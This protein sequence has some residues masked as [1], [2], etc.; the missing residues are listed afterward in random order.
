MDPQQLV[1]K[2]GPDAI[3][4]NLIEASLFLS[5]FEML[6]VAIVDGVKS[7]YLI[8][9]DK[10]G[11]TYADKYKNQVLALSP[12]ALEASCLHLV[13]LGA[14]GDADVL[15]VQTIRQ[16]RNKIAH[17]LPSFLLEPHLAVNLELLERAA[18]LLDRIGNFFGSISV[19]TDPAFD[20]QD[21]DYSG[22]R[23]LSSI[24]LRYLIEAAR[25]NAAH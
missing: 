19:D 3:K 4:R 18:D 20:H 22:I 14:I 10:N 1:D 2:L 5:A 8:G 25:Q 16:H 23:S 7:F 11:F 13:S 17:E 12:H 9:F 21:V 24:F 15:L 6:K